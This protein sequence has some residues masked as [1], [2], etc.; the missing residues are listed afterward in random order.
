VP[1]VTAASPDT[2]KLSATVVSEVA[3]PIV[4]AIPLVSVASFNA[5]VAFVI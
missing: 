5:P 1:P 4:T 3:C 2:V